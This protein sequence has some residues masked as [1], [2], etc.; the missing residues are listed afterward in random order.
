MK[1][2][3][4]KAMIL[5]FAFAIVGLLFV[6]LFFIRDSLFTGGNDEATYTQK[7]V[8]ESENLVSVYLDSISTAKSS[9]EYT[10]NFIEI[11]QGTE[12]L[13]YTISKNQKFNKY[14][15]LTGPNGTDILTDKSKQVITHYAYTMMLTGDILEKTNTSTNEVTYEIVNARITYNR[16]PFVLLSNQN[17][18]CLRNKNA[19]KEK[20]VNYNEFIEA[21]KDVEKRGEM[22]S[23]S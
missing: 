1:K 18:V 10:E 22:I 6:G 8:V 17:S 14:I 20:I 2:L 12:I 3:S 15:Q 5:I 23:W 19:N 4:R 11:E 21:L 7:I 16:I 13:G 9:E